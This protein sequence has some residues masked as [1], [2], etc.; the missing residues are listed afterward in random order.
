MQVEEEKSKD[1]YWQREEVPIAPEGRHSGRNSQSTYLNQELPLA[2]QVTLPQISALRGEESE[3]RFF[4]LGE[5][6]AGSGLQCWQAAFGESQLYLPS[7]LCSKEKRG[8]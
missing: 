8:I 6:G 2:G 3:R 7:S 4:L 1:P 5:A